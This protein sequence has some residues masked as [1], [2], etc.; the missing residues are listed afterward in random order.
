MNVYQLVILRSVGLR[1]FLLQEL[2]NTSYAAH[3]G[4]RKTTSAL[5]E[6]VLWPNRDADVKR[7]VAGC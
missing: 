1:Q 7:F 6:W 4:V 2:H 5:L 3:F